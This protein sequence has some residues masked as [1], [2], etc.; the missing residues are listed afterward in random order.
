MKIS[1]VVCTHSDER[2]LQLLEAVA[3]LRVQTRPPDEILVVVD[4]NPDLSARVAES[5]RGVRV[6]QHG[7]V[8]GLSGARNAGTSAASGN[9]VAYLDDDAVAEPGWLRE[10]A[11]HYADPAV[12]GAGGSAM[13][14]WESGRPRWWPDEF[15]WVVGCGYRGQPSRIAPVRNLMG[16]NMTLRR[17]AV[18]A[19]GGFDIGLGRTAGTAAGCEETELCI[20]MAAARP[21]GVFLLDPGARVHHNVPRERSTAGYYR[22]RCLAE[23]VSKARMT[24]CTPAA[25]ALSTERVYMRRTLPAGVGRNVAQVVSGEGAGILRASAIILGAG[26]TMCGFAG[27]RMCGSRA[28]AAAPA[29]ILPLILD[30]GQDALSPRPSGEAGY[31]R[32]LCLFLRDGRPV[33]RRM[34]ALDG[35][36]C[37]SVGSLRSHTGDEPARRRRSEVTVAIATRGRPAALAQCIDSVRSGTE[38]PARIIV[39]DNAPT[40]DV[41]ERAV[42]QLG[43]GACPVVYL[44][45]DRPGLA[46]AHNA[47]IPHLDTPIVAFTDDDV[48]VHGRWLEALLAAFAAD[49][50]TVCVTGMI[51]P[52]E[53]DTLAQQWVEARAVFD[54][55]LQ[56]A[57]FDL[58]V[59]RP[60]DPLFPLTAGSCGSGAN[61]AFRTGYLRAAGGFDPA[62]GAGTAAMGG[63]DLAAFYDVV[64]GGHRLTYEPAAIVMHPH[65]RDYAQLRR[66]AYGY[67]VGLGAYLMRCAIDDPRMLA[68][69]ARNAVPAVARVSGGGRE[70]V[71]PGLPP[72]PRDLVWAQRR[73]M[74]AGPYRYLQSRRRAARTALG[75]VRA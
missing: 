33:G 42:A 73:G 39:V 58:A 18:V 11:R 43:A 30:N 8:A 69:L 5:C 72:Y 67:G 38:V 15:D 13:P 21:G 63:D 40:D 36:A 4:G 17:E 46:H 70:P 61:M 22:R 53:L 57:V 6:I 68:V 25:A 37:A 14:R 60:G 31:G 65:H 62:L 54:K 71:I 16:C 51:A 74:A 23:G 10:L 55:G 52:R 20:R 47:A 1:A 48:L 56:R 66:Q 34:E 19:A 59:P 12:L 24:Q 28:P 3:S 50:A 27:A 26:L 9:V 75:Q 44:R 32:A 2:F 35:T 41:S 7:A 64:R 29:P 49:D 45:E